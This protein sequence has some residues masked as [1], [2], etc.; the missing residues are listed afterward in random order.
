MFFALAL[1]GGAATGDPAQV[2]ALGDSLTAGYGL[3]ED[4]GLTVQLGRWLDDHG[5]PARIINAGLSGDT[6]GGARARLAWA[7]DDPAL[8]GGADALIVAL[9]GNDMLRGLPPEE[10]RAN[11]DAIL[12][13]ADA[14][15]LPVLLAGHQAPGN[16]GAAWQAGYR[17]L[18]PDLAEAHGAI[19]L[20]DLLAPIRALPDAERGAAM[21]GD[22]LHPSASGV[23]LVVGALGPAVQELLERVDDE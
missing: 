15:G 11:L 7:L 6:T 19:L 22:G 21:Q 5:S 9:G 14:R 20:P 4:Q 1:C 16:F 3:P 10:A 23:A 18:Y 17:A 2:V 8:D 13:E 12:S